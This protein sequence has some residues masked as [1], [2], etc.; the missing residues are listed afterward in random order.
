MILAAKLNSGIGDKKCWKSRNARYRPRNRC[1]VT[2]AVCANVFVFLLEIHAAHLCRLFKI[3]I[4]PCNFGKA[5]LSTNYLKVS[6][7]TLS[8]KRW[9]GSLIEVGRAFSQLFES[10]KGLL[11][12]QRKFYQERLIIS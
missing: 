12:L 7:S 8:R 6:I 4:V 9:G 10:E 1:W 2:D 5:S 11:S 3:Y